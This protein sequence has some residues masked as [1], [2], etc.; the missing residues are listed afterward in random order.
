MNSKLSHDTRLRC[1]MVDLYYALFGVKE[2]SSVK[3]PELAALYQPQKV[4]SE[5]LD[6]PDMKN[7]IELDDQVVD[8]K[9]EASEPNIEGDFKSIEIITETVEDRE[10]KPEMDDQVV[11]IETQLEDEL[12]MKIET[13]DFNIIEETMIEPKKVDVDAADGPSKK[14]AKLEYASDNSQSQPSIDLNEFAVE[15]E[16]KEHGSKVSVASSILTGIN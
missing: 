1:D 11:M 12:V 6:D 10:F 16:V 5:G 3:N 8:I 14:R 9:D 15:G 4:E 2:P 7:M 13:E